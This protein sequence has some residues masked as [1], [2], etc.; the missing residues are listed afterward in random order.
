LLFSQKSK[1]D[2][3]NV[4]SSKDKDKPS[5]TVPVPPIF[6]S[7]KHS[8]NSVAK[9]FFKGNPPV[10]VISSKDESPAAKQKGPEDSKE[11]NEQQSVRSISAPNDHYVTPSAKKRKTDEIDETDEDEEDDGTAEGILLLDDDDD[12]F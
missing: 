7:L 1:A 9:F 4:S 10:K 11:R 3:N 5:N 2:D 12:D 6:S 8:G